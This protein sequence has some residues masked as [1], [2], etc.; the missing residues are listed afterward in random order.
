MKSEA[1]SQFPRISKGRNHRVHMLRSV[2][3]ESIHLEINLEDF[4]SAVWLGSLWHACLAVYWHQSISCMWHRIHGCQWQDNFEPKSSLH[5]QGNWGDLYNTYSR[6]LVEGGFD[7]RLGR[8]MWNPSS[9]RSAPQMH[10]ER[11]GWKKPFFFLGDC[12]S[13]VWSGVLCTIPALSSSRLDASLSLPTHKLV[14]SRN[15]ASPTIMFLL[16]GAFSFFSFAAR[17]SNE[18]PLV[19]TT[20][21]FLFSATT[22]VPTFL[23]SRIQCR[24]A[25]SN[26]NPYSIS[27]YVGLNAANKLSALEI[28]DF[29]LNEGGDW[30]RAPCSSLRYDRCSNTCANPLYMRRI[31]RAFVGIIYIHN[32]M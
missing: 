17:S 1:S 10:E 20:L 14:L 22:S 4:C 31:S 16:D 13:G 7:I 23:C 11:F 25:A 3:F 30:I 32:H 21:L 15:Q 6:P 27:K 24:A 9:G 19:G 26:S 12:T 2:Y 28:V 29:L 5:K 8:G 18:T